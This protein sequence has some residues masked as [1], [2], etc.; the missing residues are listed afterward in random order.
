[1]SGVEYVEAMEKAR[2]DAIDAMASEMEAN[3]KLFNAEMEAGTM[4]Q[5]L[6]KSLTDIYHRIR[7]E[8]EILLGN[9]PKS[10]KKPRFRNGT[11]I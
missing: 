1:M 8:R 4:T 10:A 5:K 2:Q 3:R 6:N 7:I 9:L 11:Y